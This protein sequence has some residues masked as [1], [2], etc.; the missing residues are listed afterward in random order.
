MNNNM[1]CEVSVLDNETADELD[2]DG[3][4]ASIAMDHIYNNTRENVFFQELYRDGA[5]TMFSSDTK[6]GLAV[7]FSYDYFHLFYPLLVDFNMNPSLVSDINEH[8][9]KLKNKIG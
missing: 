4:S 6:I 7:L 3:D 5:A 1:A 2:Y 9:I 8:Y